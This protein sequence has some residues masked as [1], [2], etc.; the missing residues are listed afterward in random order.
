MGGEEGP[1]GEASA[2]G[3]DGST[4][5]GAKGGADG[6]AVTFSGYRR[7]AASLAPGVMDSIQW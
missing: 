7:L 6:T 1:A 2:G 5:G 4:P 3:A